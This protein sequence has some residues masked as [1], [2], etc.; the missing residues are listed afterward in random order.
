MP[1]LP[2]THTAIKQGAGGILKVQTA[3]VPELFEPGMILVKTIA[4]ALNPCD[5]KMP[6]RFPT[7]GATDGSDFAGIIV[8][9]GT[10]VQRTD[11]HIGDRVCGAVHASNPA[12]LQSGSFAEYV[13]TYS[14]LV[15]KVPT[16]M[17]WENAAVIG[18]CVHGSVGLSLWNSLHLP[19]HPDRPTK[20]PEY[21]LVYGGSTASGTMAIQLV[22]CAG[23]KCITTC[24]PKNFDLVKSYGAEE[25]FDYND[26]GC[27]EKIK[28][29]TANRLK[30]VFDI[31]TETKTMKLCYGAL[32][33]V[34]GRYTG[35]EYFNP[36]LAEGLRKT[37]K[38]D[39]VI[40]LVLPGKGVGLPSGYG[41]EPDPEAREFGR[42][43]FETMQRLVDAKKIKSHPPRVMTG[44]F[45]GILKGVEIM[46]RK[47]ISGEKLVY[48]IN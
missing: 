7:P 47:E 30:Y 18:G 6:T 14:D 42:R 22:R 3:P 13:A 12:C 9:I 33:R 8:K 11:L 48:F 20:T 10:A 24:S 19:G 25:A 1:D 35:L 40:G 26:P 41:R 38:A 44:K 37:V 15:L 32:G 46:R 39:W 2:T 21:V 34:G 27:A 4:V 23:M 5:Y 28:A 31:I 45:Q 16:D 29:Y 43:W 17:A 36:A